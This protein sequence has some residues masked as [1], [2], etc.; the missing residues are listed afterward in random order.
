MSIRSLPSEVMR[1]SRPLAISLIHKSLSRV[2]AIFV[3]SGDGVGLTSF[4]GACAPAMLAESKKK[5]NT[6]FF[7]TTKLMNSPKKYL[8]LKIKNQNNGNN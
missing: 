3:E 4:E 6:I 5:A 2:K 7:I 1:R 8:S